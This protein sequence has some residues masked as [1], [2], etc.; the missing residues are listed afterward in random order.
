VIEIFAN[1]QNFCSLTLHEIQIQTI[2]GEWL[3]TKPAFNSIWNRSARVLEL[4]QF[5]HVT[6]LLY[7][8]PSLVKWNG[9]MAIWRHDR[10]EVRCE[11]QTVQ[12]DVFHKL[13]ILK[14][15]PLNFLINTCHSSVEKLK[16]IENKKI[17]WIWTRTLC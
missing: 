17:E 8:I 11:E 6:I 10:K 5:S 12:E 3:I 1:I 15:Q 2:L 16:L 9:R 14:S 7:F 4:V 13:R